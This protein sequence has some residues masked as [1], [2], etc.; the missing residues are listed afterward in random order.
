VTLSGYVFVPGQTVTIWVV[1]QNTGARVFLGTTH[2]S[3][4]GKSYPPPHG[5]SYT[6]YPWRYETGVL[7]VNYWAPQQLAADVAASQGHLE[8][9]ASVEGK[10]LFGFRCPKFLL[11]FSALALKLM[12]MPTLL[13]NYRTDP[14]ENFAL[15]SDGGDSTVLFHQY[16]VGGGPASWTPVAGMTSYPPSFPS[17]AWSVGSY[18]VDGGTK[19]IYALICAPNTPGQYPMVVYNHGGI[20]AGA[21]ADSGSLHGNVTNTGGTLPS[22]PDGI[23]RLSSGSGAVR[24]PYAPRA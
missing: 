22:D 7:A 23:E 17:V 15:N 9:F 24:S 2:A 12:L 13:P 21:A 20:N 6:L 14:E 19:N 3:K 16:G 5:H 18:T 8:L 10:C 1:D 11:T 4:S